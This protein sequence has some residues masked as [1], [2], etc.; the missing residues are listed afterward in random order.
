MQNLLKV[1]KHN[2]LIASSYRL[3]L[4]EIRI[5]LYGISLINPNTKEFPI[6]YKIN[7]NKFA[8]IFQIKEDRLFSELKDVVVKKFWERDFSYIDEKGKV[9][10]RRW[11]TD[12]IYHDGEGH[13][14]IFYNYNIKKMLHNLQEHFTSYYLDRVKG[15]KSVYSI[16]VY[17]LSIMEYSKLKLYSN[18]V[19]FRIKISY[20]RDLLGLENK[21]KYFRDIRLFVLERAKKE[22]N[23]QSD[24]K[25]DYKVE[26]LGRTPYEIEFSVKIKKTEED[27]KKA[28]IALKNKEAK[29]KD[30]RA[31]HKPM[32]STSSNI[33]TLGSSM[34]SIL[35]KMEKNID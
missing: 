22:I 33:T 20:L 32:H 15:L 30:R 13:L 25:I 10:M 14:E 27:F 8:R 18:I 4:M 28:E 26:K 16:R 7:I 12:I 31:N 24:I 3:S 2:A 9:I 21:Y 35:K 5:V 11:L 17:E 19:K 6:S 23:K 34:V 29:E 1:T